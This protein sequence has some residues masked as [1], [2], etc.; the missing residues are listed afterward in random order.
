MVIIIL[1]IKNRQTL[2]HYLSDDE[3]YVTATLRHLKGLPIDIAALCGLQRFVASMRH[4]Y[5][6]RK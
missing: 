2:G 1:V 5:S 4:Q 6:K 3:I